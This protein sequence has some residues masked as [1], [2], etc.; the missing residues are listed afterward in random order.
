MIL[1]LAYYGDPILRKKAQP[2]KVFDEALRKFVDDLIETLH[3]YPNGVG[4]AA[5]QVG[6]SL[7][8]FITEVPVFGPDKKEVIPGPIRIF[9]NPKIL[10]VSENFCVFQEGCL[11]IPNVYEDVERPIHLSLKFD[12]LE[13]NS[14]I[15]EFQG[16]QARVILHENDHVNGVLFVDRIHGKKRQAL[17]PLLRDVKKRF[18][19]P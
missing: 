3:T 2:I 14:H 8:I 18:K 1:K 19:K 6:H 4:L 10:S 13:G 9:I 16:Y 11:S 12:D 7:S 15:E 17:E 5:P